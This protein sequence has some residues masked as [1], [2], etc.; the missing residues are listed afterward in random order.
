M[1]A[2][3]APSFSAKLHLQ[4]SKTALGS[5]LLLEAQAQ[6]LLS[7]LRRARALPAASVQERLFGEALTSAAVLAASCRHCW[8][9]LWQL[10]AGSLVADNERAFFC[11]LDLRRGGESKCC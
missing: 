2:W 1:P 4:N 5:R 8:A 9:L 10:L 7:T 3:I 11:L 6:A